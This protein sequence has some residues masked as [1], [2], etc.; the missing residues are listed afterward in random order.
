MAGRKGQHFY[1]WPASIA[2]LFLAGLGWQPPVFAEEPEDIPAVVQALA[3]AQALGKSK[4]TLLDGIHQASDGSAVALS[5]KF[6]LDDGKLSLSVYIAEKGL[7]VPAGENVLQEVSGSPEQD[8]WSPSVAVL[9]DPQDVVYAAEQLTLMAIGHKSLADLIG[10]AEKKY[11]GTVLSIT[12]IVKNHRAVAA[13]LVAQNGTVRTVI[14]P[15]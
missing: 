5:A 11:S 14:L 7:A 13:I 1:A 2:V 10:E 12:P 15:L 8:K 4:H 6:E 9:K 3:V